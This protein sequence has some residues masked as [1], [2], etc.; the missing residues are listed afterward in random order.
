MGTELVFYHVEATEPLLNCQV[1]HCEDRSCISA[2]GRMR[3]WGMLTALSWELFS[4][5]PQ[6]API[7]ESQA[8]TLCRTNPT[9][10]SRGEA[11]LATGTCQ[12]ISKCH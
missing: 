2:A 3:L 6:D 5:C 8:C 11:C 10:C 4:E 9:P 12:Q 1:P 7:L